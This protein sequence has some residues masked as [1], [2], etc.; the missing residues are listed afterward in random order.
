MIEKLKEYLDLKLIAILSGGYGLFI[1]V[2]L[3]RAAY[4]RVNFFKEP[5]E[6]YELIKSN[7]IDWVVITVF[8]FFLVFTTKLM[9][10][11]KTK[12]VFI[13]FIHL[14]FSFFIGFFTIFLSNIVEKFTGSSSTSLMSFDT[15]I[16]WFVR[17]MNL[18]FL[19]Y[20]ALVTV[21]Y[22]YYYLK[23]NEESKVKALK[24]QDQLSKAHLKF[25]QSQ[26][27]PHF[28][29]NT[30]NGIHSLMDISLPKSK[31]MV[32]DLSDLLR[33]VLDKKDQ[34]LIEL[35][36]E[37]FIL[38]KYLQIK[39]IRFSD[40]LKFHVTV[41]E[42]LENVLVPNMLIQPLVENATKHGYEIKH[43]ILDI[44]ID[45]KKQNKKLI[46]KVKNNG[47]K[48]TEK[49]SLLFEKGTGLSNLKE[50][51]NTL[52]K[53]N[54]KLTLYNKQDFVITEIHFPIQL[55]ISEIP[56]SFKN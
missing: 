54:Y 15:I 43:G 50:R 24:L 22:M 21:V 32:V 8:I 51:L 12:M 34:N 44:Y 27:H 17:L 26:M 52:Y 3:F 11:K 16:E 9:M 30:L 14:F 48:L 41:E 7:I 19:I 31:N 1:L 46:V 40:H 45:I 49:T 5:I 38:Q 6:W 10:H 33:N 42:G 56:D 53:D 13:I 35:Q 55:S 37:L 47:K 28:L 29:F 39:K 23:Q 25:L 20:A 36:E 2:Q 18:H 4:I